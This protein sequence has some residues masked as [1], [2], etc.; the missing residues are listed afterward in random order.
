MNLRLF[1]SWLNIQ[2]NII[3]IIPSVTEVI[4]M[5]LFPQ[6]KVVVAGSR[7]ELLISGL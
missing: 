5:L 4:L 3:A 6:G 1:L 2:S 7:F